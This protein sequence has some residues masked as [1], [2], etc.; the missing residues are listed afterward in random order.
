[1]GKLL[2]LLLC[3]ILPASSG[4]IAWAQ[5]APGG[6][7]PANP[8]RPAFMLTSSGFEDGGVLP[9]KFSATVPDPVTP[10]LN[11]IN[12]PAGTQS[13]VLQVR[14]ME[15][16]R[17]KDFVD[18]IHWFAFNIPGNA[19]SLA[20]GLPSSATLPDG[21]VQANNYGGHPGFAPPGAPPGPYHHY[22]VE[23]FA[24]DTSLS[25]RSDATREQVLAAMG[26][27]ILG[28]SVTTFRFHR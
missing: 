6:G 12:P 15:P 7:A 2:K 1:M 20:Q 28:K 16:V 27:H 10:P 26:G 4:G 9:N 17:N 24:L 19:T 21:T 18:V 8:P 11:W 14:D 22:L 13:Y 25:L 3:T 5:G 23:L